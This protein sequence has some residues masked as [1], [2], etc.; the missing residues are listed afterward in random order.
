MGRRWE[1]LSPELKVRLF[2]LE[3]AEAVITPEVRAATRPSNPPSGDEIFSS[4]SRRAAEHLKA[5]VYKHK[6]DSNWS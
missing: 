2:H 4:E 1:E 3:K 5:V 6:T